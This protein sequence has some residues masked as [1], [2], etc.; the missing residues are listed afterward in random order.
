MMS[1]NLR[2]S[3]SVKDT[4]IGFVFFVFIA[5]T[6]VLASCHPVAA[7]G[8]RVTPMPSTSSIGTPSYLIGAYSQDFYIYDPY[9]GIPKNI[10]IENYGY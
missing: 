6:L 4:L 3:E 10:R 5:V 8:G 2:W 7:E 9:L 1:S